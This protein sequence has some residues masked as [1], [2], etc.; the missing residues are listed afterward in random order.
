MMLAFAAFIACDDEPAVNPLSDANAFITNYANMAFANYSDALNDATALNTAIDAFVANPNA[1]THQAAKD[2]WLTARESYGTTEAFRFAG[3]PIDEYGE[4]PEGALNAWPLDEAY[5]DYIDNNGTITS[6]GIINDGV[7]T[8][9]KATLE[10]LNEQG[11]EANISI[12]FHAIE[13]LLWGQ[14]NTAPSMEIAG[15]RSYTDFTSTPGAGISNGDRRADYLV[16]VSELLVEH[17]EYVVDEWDASI[18]GNFR[19]GFLAS[20]ASEQVK[21]IIQSLAIFS[22]GELSGERMIVAY[23]NLDQED[24]HSCFSDNTHRD[25][26]LNQKGIGNI[27]KG[28]YG[29]VSGTG[30]DDLVALADAT[31]NDEVLA[32]ITQTA[33]DCNAMHVPFDNAI[34]DAAYRPQVL[35]AANGLRDLGDKLVEAASALGF[36]VSADLPE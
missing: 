22:K 28:S 30:L 9:D 33:T 19:A 21:T 25:I 15:Q 31:V 29:S 26:I 5:V 11:G 27:Y 4:A 6:D 2:A 36:T 10:G 12:G 34:S 18:S 16:A 32:L 14:D 7:T 17:L 3:G 24:E 35:T 20:D 13:F 1:T 23:T 8:I